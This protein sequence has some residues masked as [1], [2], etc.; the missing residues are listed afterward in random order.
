MAS[1]YW[2]IDIGCVDIWGMDRYLKVVAWM[3]KCSQMLVEWVWP[4][5]PCLCGP[6]DSFA[7]YCGLQC[8]CVRLRSFCTITSNLWRLSRA[9]WQAVATETSVLTAPLLQWLKGFEDNVFGRLAA[10][11]QWGRADPS[12]PL[13]HVSRLEGSWGRSTQTTPLSRRYDI[14]MFLKV[15]LKYGLDVTPGE[16]LEVC[17]N[18][19]TIK[20]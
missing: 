14:K 16:A 8:C 3:D 1:G 5:P 15:E 9:M 12:R 2:I 10:T 7:S 19:C 6:W 13:G 18:E 4:S 17:E 11:V 20:K